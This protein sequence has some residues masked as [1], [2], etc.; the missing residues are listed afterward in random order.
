[1]YAQARKCYHCFPLC[2]PH[3]KADL[4]Y[5]L[6]QIGDSITV[7]LPEGGMVCHVITFFFWEEWKKHRDVK[8][9]SNYSKKTDWLFIFL[10]ELS[11]YKSL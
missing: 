5:L 7:N 9:C 6:K 8:T 3:R 4:P 11:C 2:D 10:Q 1:M